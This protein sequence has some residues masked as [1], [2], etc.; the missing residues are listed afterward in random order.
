MNKD[1]LKIK[2]KFKVF[3]KNKLSKMFCLSR[4]FCKKKEKKEYYEIYKCNKCN[5]II[6][7]DLYFVMDKVYCSDKCRD[8]YII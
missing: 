3:L 8:M 7:N 2:M 1:F 4:I 6:T 5:I